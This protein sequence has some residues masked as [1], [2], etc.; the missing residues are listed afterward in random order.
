[1]KIENEE[2]IPWDPPV[3]VRVSENIFTSEDPPVEVLRAE[4]KEITSFEVE[5]YQ[6]IDEKEAEIIRPFF[7][8]TD[9]GNAERLR[10]DYGHVLR[11]CHK[12][13]SWLIWNGRYWEKDENGII[14][15][16]A[17]T[18]IARMYEDAIKIKDTAGKKAALKFA[19]NTDSTYRINGMITLTQHRDGIPVG[20]EELDKPKHLINTEN[21]TIDLRTGSTRPFLQEDFLTKMLPVKYEHTAR[22][23]RWIK[24][25]NEIM[26]ND[27]GRID[28]LQR[29]IGY[30]LTGFTKEQC[31]FICYGKGKNGKS[32]FL[33]ILSALLGEYGQSLPIESICVKKWEGIPNDIARLKGARLAVSAEGGEGKRLDEGRIKKMTGKDDLLTGRFMRAEYFDFYPEFK[34]WLATNHKPRIKGTDD[35]IWRR[36]KLIPFNA[37]FE[38]TTRDEDMSEKLLEELEGILIWAIDGCVLWFEDGLQECDEIDRATKRYRDEEDTLERF[39]SDCSIKDGGEIGAKEFRAEYKLWCETENE[40]SFKG[41]DFKD[42]LE[43]H[44]VFYKRLKTSGIYFM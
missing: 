18:T 33:R 42:K 34:I 17:D 3:E 32:T 39:V 28:F 44:G 24:F 2:E 13:Q 23:P 14:Y 43:E 27:N 22:C 1:M 5:A 9:G 25:L 8:A 37:V 16:Y 41:K 12:W 29:A 40:Y 10:Y 21:V 19:M 31:L 35:A 26:E 36:I 7:H 15:K 38:G 4:K 11:Y 30:S 20:P 6:E